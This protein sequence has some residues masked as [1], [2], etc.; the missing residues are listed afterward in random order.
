M[1]TKVGAA[2]IQLQRLLD[3]QY[4]NP[5]LMFQ[6]SNS[7]VESFAKRRAGPALSAL[8][9]CQPSEAGHLPRQS[10]WLCREGRLH[11]QVLKDSV[12]SDGL[13]LHGPVFDLQILLLCQ[14]MRFRHA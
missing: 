11:G 4:A 12:T 9:P 5:Y 1:N 2:F 6:G 8:I 13:A 10:R 7:D 3:V 14:L